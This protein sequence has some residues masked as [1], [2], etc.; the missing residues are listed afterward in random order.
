MNSWAIRN[1]V[2]VFPVPQGIDKIPLSFSEKY[3]MAAFLAVCWYS[4]FS[5]SG[6]NTGSVDSADSGS[7][8]MV[9]GLGLVVVGLGVL[10]AVLGSETGAG[11]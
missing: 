4:N 5:G 11:I 1:A 10:V 7:D 3:S 8:T 9:I 6:L 2:N